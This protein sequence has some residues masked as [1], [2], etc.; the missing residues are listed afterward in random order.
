MKI[1]AWSPLNKP[2]APG[3]SFGRRYGYIEIFLIYKENSHAHVLLNDH[4]YMAWCQWTI[5]SG[6]D[7]EKLGPEYQLL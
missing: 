2:D 1:W 3:L 4:G 7:C 6:G 5:G